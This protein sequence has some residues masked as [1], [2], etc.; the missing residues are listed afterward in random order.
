LSEGDLRVEE[1]A[2]CLLAEGRQRIP[3]G[4]MMYDNG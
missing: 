4:K 1:A 2:P 3:E